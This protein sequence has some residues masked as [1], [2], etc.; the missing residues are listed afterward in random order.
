MDLSIRMKIIHNKKHCDAI[1]LKL[2]GRPLISVAKLMIEAKAS[3]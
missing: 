3:I 1:R 2:G